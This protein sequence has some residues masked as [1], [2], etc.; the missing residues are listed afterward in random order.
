ML[1][2]KAALASK[3]RLTSG[4]DSLWNTENSLHTD[5]ADFLSRFHNITEGW[6]HNVPYLEQF[7]HKNVMIC[8]YIKTMPY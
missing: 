6:E 1:I 5:T 3:I 2:M 4:A 8:Q 7:C